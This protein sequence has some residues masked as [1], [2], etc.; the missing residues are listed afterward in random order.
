MVICSKR[1]TFPTLKLADLA[2]LGGGGNKSL[3]ACLGVHCRWGL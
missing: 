1:F 3:F 2:G